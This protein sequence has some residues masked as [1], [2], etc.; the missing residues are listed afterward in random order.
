VMAS[1]AETIIVVSMMRC[2]FM[3]MQGVRAAVWQ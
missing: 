3:V 2:R 1:A